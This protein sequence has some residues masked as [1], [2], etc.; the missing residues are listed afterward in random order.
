MSFLFVYKNSRCHCCHLC[1]LAS[2]P[3][4]V[5]TA[6]ARVECEQQFSFQGQE[7]ERNVSSSFTSLNVKLEKSHTEI[8]AATGKFSSPSFV[9]SLQREL[10]KE[11]WIQP[12]ITEFQSIIPSGKSSSSLEST[13]AHTGG[14]CGDRFC[15]WLQDS[16]AGWTSSSQTVL[17]SKIEAPRRSPGRGLS[18][19]TPSI[20]LAASN[21]LV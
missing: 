13:Q 7:K 20:T 12:I 8:S 2:L 17:T 10:V 14:V 4:E 6:G 11:G 5:S 15:P 3:A 9:I 1:S 18:T 19:I 16:G 21:E